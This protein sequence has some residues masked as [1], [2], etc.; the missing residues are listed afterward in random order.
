VIYESNDNFGGKKHNKVVGLREPL[1]SNT[2]E[3]YRQDFD[4]KELP[5]FEGVEVHKTGWLDKVCYYF[6]A[7]ELLDH[8][9]SLKNN[10]VAK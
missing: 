2:V 3:K 6:D 4:L 1:R 9:V 10:E 8:H 5:K 7:V